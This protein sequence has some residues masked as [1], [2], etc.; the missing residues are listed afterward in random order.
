MLDIVLRVLGLIAL[1]GLIGTVIGIIATPFVLQLTVILAY[2]VASMIAVILRR[3]TWKESLKGFPSMA[4]PLNAIIH[5]SH[6]KEQAISYAKCVPDFRDHSYG[7]IDRNVVRHTQTPT[8]PDTNPYDAANQDTSDMVNQ[9]ALKKAPTVFH[10]IILFYRSYY[11]HST[12]VEKNQ[13]G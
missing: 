11:G 12:K 8:N 7:T 10:R 2:T 4:K 6:N 9:P 5:N 13:S 3:R 1:G